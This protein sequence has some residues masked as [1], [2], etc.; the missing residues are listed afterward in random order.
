[1]PS[2]TRDVT[3]PA[4]TH[5]EGELLCDRLEIAYTDAYGHRFRHDQGDEPEPYGALLERLHDHLAAQLVRP[6]LARRLAVY[7]GD[8]HQEV[9]RRRREGREA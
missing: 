8:H 1:M 5:Q 6:S 7:G 3:L 4:L 2:A 9:T